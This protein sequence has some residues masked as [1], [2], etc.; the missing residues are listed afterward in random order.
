MKKHGFTLIEMMLA[1]S[2]TSVIGFAIVSIMVAASSGITSKDDGRQSAIRLA[3]AKIRLTAYLAPARCI[4][5]KTSLSITLWHNDSRE[6]QTINASEIRWIT[7]DPTTNSLQ[8]QFVSFPSNW[9]DSKKIAADIECSI[10]SDFE[11]IFSDFNEN[12]LIAAIPILDSLASCS[13]WVNDQEVN[14]AHQVSM[15]LSFQT[16]LGETPHSIIDERIRLHQLP[17]EQQL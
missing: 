2:I 13:F 1:I 17:M 7:F 12:G 3:T 5:D 9:S 14:D 4:L 6:S 10:N 8:A 15:L 16:E 11:V